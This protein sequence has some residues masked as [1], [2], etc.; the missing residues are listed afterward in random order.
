LRETG[1]ATCPSPP[2]PASPHVADFQI[3]DTDG[4]RALS[5]PVLLLAG[6]VDEDEVV[7]KLG[8]DGLN[9]LRAK[10]LL[11]YP[12][13]LLGR[14]PEE[15][16]D[17]FAVEVLQRMDPVARAVIAQVARP[18]L[19]A[20]VASGFPRAGRS[21]GVPLKLKEFFGSVRRLAWAKENGCPWDAQTC[22][23]AAGALCV[24][25]QRNV[26]VLMY[27]REHGCPW[28]DGSMC[29]RA[30]ETGNLEVLRYAREQGCPWGGV[31][32]GLPMEYD[33][34]GFGEPRGTCEAAARGGHLDML[35]WA[36]EQ[37]CEW[38]EGA[39]CRHAAEGGNVEV[40]MY[41]REHGCPWDEGL[42]RRPAELG[43]LDMLKCLCELG[44]PWAEHTTSSA[45]MGG[46]R[47]YCSPPHEALEVLKW[48]WEKGCPWDDDTLGHAAS[49]GGVELVKWVREH[50]CP[51]NEETCCVA[52]E[53]G[54]LEALIWLRENGC[55][56]DKEEC[57]ERARVYE[58]DGETVTWIEEQ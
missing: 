24:S 31:A 5:R 27:A 1:L 37:G 44:C 41:V 54:E 13:P 18:L 38:V 57:L 47:F 39:M 29:Y 8:L 10:G 7:D 36:R 21:A 3:S 25:P 45:A 26:E 30:A 28:N 35:R 15:L 56:W 42:T 2:P 52:A 6:E 22:E 40:V 12:S 17:V 53:D 4:E 32:T 14:L 50:G 43:N 49:C 16:P 11:T 20:V 9:W 51:W 23:L 34:Q 48:L 19:A 33:F 55:P 46:S 58:L